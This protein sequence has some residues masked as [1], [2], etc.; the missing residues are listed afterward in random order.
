[1]PS[2]KDPAEDW[3]RLTTSGLSALACGEIREA[4]GCWLGAGDLAR[5]GGLSGPQMAAAYNNA[6]VAHLI[7]GRRCEALGGF[8]QARLRWVRSQQSLKAAPLEA[9]GATSVYHLQLAMDHHDAF[10]QL[11]QERVGR[12]CAMA[13][14]TTALNRCNAIPVTP[15]KAHLTFLANT[16]ADTLGPRGAALDILA[17]YD[18]TSEPAASSAIY[19]R[20]L[21]SITELR[22]RQSAGASSDIEL[23]ARLTV[24]ARPA[25]RSAVGGAA[26]LEND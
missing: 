6:G 8:T 21:D 17:E 23:A 10:A 16:L 14:A 7:Q 20:Q 4:A 18:A 5:E 12:F 11:S 26:I 15:R 19:Q 2:R 9:P 3:F 25:W 22:A 24:L 13:R 1:M